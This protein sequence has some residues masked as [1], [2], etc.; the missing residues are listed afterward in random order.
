MEFE[1]L[2]TP[3]A[4]AT[5]APLVIPIIAMAALPVGTLLGAG[6]WE[7]RG[8]LGR[9]GFGV[10]YRAWDEGR[11]CE[12]AIKE[13]FPAGCRR[14]GRSV[15]GPDFSSAAALENGKAG[16]RRQGAHLAHL[17]HPAIVRALEHFEENATVYLVMELVSGPNLLEVME[18][19]GIPPLPLRLE[20]IEQ[21]SS[22]LHEVHRAGYLHLDIKPE[23]VLLRATDATAGL[24][25]VDFDLLQARD[26]LDLTTRPLALA[27]QCGTP[28][29]APLEQYSQH[30]PLSGASDIYA[31]CA[32]F[33]HLTT[34]QVPLSAVDRAAGLILPPPLELCPELPEWIAA[35][36]VQGMALKADDRPAGVA[37][38]QSLLE[39]PAAGPPETATAALTNDPQL[40]PGANYVPQAVVLHHAPVT[41]HRVVV[42][43]AQ[44]N[45]PDSCVCC[46]SAANTTYHYKAI[47]YTWQLPLCDFCEHHQSENRLAG[48]VTAWGMGLSAVIAAAGLAFSAM[49]SSIWPLL[50]APAG[51]ILNFSAMSFGALKNSHTE[52][53]MRDTCTDMSQ[54]VTHVYNGRV[55]IW[56]F[57]NAAVATQFKALNASNVV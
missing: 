57:K 33:Y 21:L 20:W 32:T 5:L 14:H 3:K 37:E 39:E 12:V 50:L 8:V 15:V 11:Q 2:T 56:R 16:L 40:H 46:G 31:L 34:G 38:L 13:C 26:E 49:N 10:T 29:Y 18:A 23:N 52:E 47:G 9:G 7:I 54:P 25:L 41:V 45:F 24:V 17:Q 1:V 44:P 19:E 30:A 36:I 28:G 27:T 53:A 55:H 22:A 51:I 43:T 6:A 48:L 42:T 4:I 35:A